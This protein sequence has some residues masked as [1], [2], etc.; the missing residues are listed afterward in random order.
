MPGVDFQSTLQS[1]FQQLGPWAYVALALAVF[2]Q[3]ANPVGVVIPGNPL[4]FACGLFAR[5]SESVPL[6]GLLGALAVG[7]IGGSMVGFASG[8]WVGTRLW[9]R[10]RAAAMRPRLDAFFNQHGTRAVGICYFVPFVRCFVPTVA[11]ASGMPWP[12]YVTPAIVGGLVWVVLFGG[13]GYAL[14]TIPAVRQNLEIATI[15]LGLFLLI[16]GL[17]KAR[18]AQVASRQAS[19]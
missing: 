19:Q 2:I 8:R 3:A 13:G 4:V 11:G 16:Q 1:V 6:Q 18:R 7:A 14:G 5:S 15:G 10:P 9:D 17:I 12:T